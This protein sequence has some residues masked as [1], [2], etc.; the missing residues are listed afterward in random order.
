MP[1]AAVVPPSSPKPGEGGVRGRGRKVSENKAEE[2]QEEKGSKREVTAGI[3][4]QIER[5]KVENA[6]G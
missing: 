3:R 4:R 1:V 6:G 5:A 2:E